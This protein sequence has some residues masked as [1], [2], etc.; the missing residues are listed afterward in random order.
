MKMI[1]RSGF[2]V[3]ICCSVMCFLAG[4]RVSA[5]LTTADLVGTV[6]DNT[7]AVVPDAKVTVE[8][9]GTH[10]RHSA[11]TTSSGDFTFNFL[12]AGSYSVTVEA[13]SFQSFRIPNLTL[14]TGDRA[15]ADAKLQIGASNQT[16]DVTTSTSALQT[17]SSTIGSVV[18]DR[19]VQDVPLNGRNFIS[20]VQNTVGINAGPSNGI[21]SGNRPDDRRQTS[22]ISAN[23]QSDYLNNNMIDGMDNNE[24]EQGLI[25][26]R[27]SIEAIQEVRVDTSVASAEIGRAAGA[28]V[29]VITRSGTNA[30]HGSAYEF[31]RNDIFDA[32]DYFANQ[33]GRPRPEYRQNQFGGSIGGPIRK[34]KTFF[35]ADVEELRIVQGVPTGLLTVPTLFEQQNPGNLS[36][37][38]GPII[39]QNQLDPVALQYFALFPLPNVATTGFVN[40]YSGNP[41]RT[42]NATTV[43]GRVDNHFANGDSMF[44]RYSWNPVTTFTPGLYPVI[45]GIQPGGG[46]QP[47]PNNTQSQGVQIHYVHTF[48]PNL[49][50]ELGAGYGR[51]N[52]ESLPLNYGK[53]VSQMFGMPNSNISLNTS[54][55]APVVISGYTSTSLGDSQYIPLLDINNV[56]QY[57]GALTYTKGAHNIK[58]G[59]GLIRRQLNYNQYDW[60]QGLFTFSGTPLA[61]ITN[62]LEG[63]STMV[64]RTMPIENL[65]GWR[66]WEPDV[67]IQDDWRATHWLTVNLGLRWDYFS[68]ST[69]AHNHRSNFNLDT[70]SMIVASPSDPTAGVKGDYKNF[71][72]RIGFAASGHGMVFRGG[73]GITYFG[74]DGSWAINLIN[75]PYYYSFTCQ[76]GSTS[77]ALICPAGIGKIAGGVPL[78]TF[79]SINPLSGEVYEKSLNYPTSYVEQFNLA[80]QKQFGQNVVTAAYVGELGVHQYT[81]TFP[82]LPLPKPGPAQNYVYAAQLPLVNIIFYNSTLGAGNYNA[83][84]LSFERRY[85]KGLVMNANYTLAHGLNNFAIGDSPEVGEVSNNMR[86]DYGNSD[87]DVRQRFNILASYTLPFFSNATGVKRQLLGGWSVNALAYAQTGLPFM[88]YDTAHSPALINLPGITT[89]RPNRVPGQAYKLGN[90]GPNQWFNT[91]AFEQ[92]PQGTAGNAGRNQIYA[93]AVRELDASIFKDFPIHESLHLQLRAESFNLT[94]TE[95]FAAPKASISGWNAATNTP[96][97][98]GSFGQITSSL[99]GSHPRQLQFAAKLIF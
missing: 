2:L 31:V 13:Q 10:E 92:Q 17:D 12:Q 24:R 76:P 28:N 85:S 43:D 69:E 91:A 60:G 23:G 56:F 90:R 95:N 21:G 48:S 77:A 68:P 27:P 30:F 61:S 81:G 88:V 16:V 33:A 55:L 38:G 22:E 46:A 79:G 37:Q 47:G 20:L 72:P 82:N 35:Y 7:G 25:M 73:F 34:D 87:Y 36:D 8:N 99:I 89:D 53:N 71:A 57:M 51:V 63:N 40:N 52:I 49:V 18:T 83:A 9:L 86:Y 4:G 70:L 41:L 62:F 1:R 58:M 59:G 26:V 74:Y 3:A 64:Q 66:F 11:Q 54:G 75:A 15:R 14:G 6:T 45:G 29:N 84:Q 67:Y 94:N 42:Q 32:N 44:V 80:L 65:F 19:T 5:Q 39:P 93:P 50:M 97:S 98:A 78:P 96:T